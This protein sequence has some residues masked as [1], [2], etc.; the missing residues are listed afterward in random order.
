MVTE[1]YEIEQPNEKRPSY[2][3]FVKDLPPLDRQPKNKIN[4]AAGVLDYQKSDIYARGTIKAALS[5]ETLDEVEQAERCQRL[6]QAVVLQALLDICYARN[7]ETR[8][9]VKWEAIDW[10]EGRKE[11]EDRDLVLIF[12]DIHIKRLMKG[13]ARIREHEY[14]L[15]ATTG[16]MKWRYERDGI[17]AREYAERIDRVYAKKAE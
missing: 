8:D 1:T 10:L 2:F 7:S 14:D 13:W 5:Q 3:R 4:G 17:R 12:A 16:K 6:W 9:G 11:I 15:A